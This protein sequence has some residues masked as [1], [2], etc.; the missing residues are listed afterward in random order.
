MIGN[1]GSFNKD[2]STEQSSSKPLNL[3]LDQQAQQSILNNEIGRR[4]EIWFKHT[5]WQLNDDD[6]LAPCAQFLMKDILYTKISNQQELDCVEHTL[7]IESCKVQ[8]LASQLQQQMSL[9]SQKSY[10]G[11]PSFKD[12]MHKKL[13]KSQHFDSFVLKGLF[14]NNNSQQSMDGLSNLI[15]NG[16][17]DIDSNE[18]LADENGVSFLRRT[19]FT[20]GLKKKKNFNSNAGI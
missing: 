9:K 19:I 15:D 12:K 2:S 6:G 20:S 16:S 5:R 13:A 17:A 8:D 10:T 18:L 1:R 4:Y 14:E 7:E 11:T 3:D